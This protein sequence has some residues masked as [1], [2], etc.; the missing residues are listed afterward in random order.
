VTIRSVDINRWDE[1]GRSPTG[2]DKLPSHRHS[3]STRDKGDRPRRRLAATNC[4]RS[5]SQQKLT[6]GLDLGD[7]SSWYCARGERR[8]AAGT[9][10]TT[11]A[12]ALLRS[13]WR[14]A[15]LPHCVGDG[16]APAVGEPL[17]ERVGAR[18]DRGARAERAADRLRGCNVRNMNP[19]K[20]ERLSPERQAALEP[21]LAG[22]ES[23]SERIR[24]YNE[25][26][27]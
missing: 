7:R 8:S 12:K 24:E 13:V 17:A 5:F 25:L 6:I 19:E 16:H 11:T 9:A 21:L 26:I 22:I 20:A 14:N 1:F 18:S 2:C 23:V 3:R 10:L 15:A 27:E 4:S